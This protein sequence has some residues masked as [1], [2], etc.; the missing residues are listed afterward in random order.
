MPFCCERHKCFKQDAN[1]GHGFPPMAFLF[2]GLQFGRVSFVGEGGFT[3]GSRTS[4]RGVAG[5]L[6]HSDRVR[7]MTGSSPCIIQKRGEEKP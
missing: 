3:P 6:E 4:I 1:Q 5:M 2:L 7:L